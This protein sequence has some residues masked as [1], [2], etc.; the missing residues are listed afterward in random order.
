VCCVHLA[1]AVLPAVLPAS[2][3]YHFPLCRAW[4]NC[5]REP[6]ANNPVPG[7]KSTS[8]KVLARNTRTF[9]VTDLFPGI[10]VLAYGSQ[11]RLCHALQWRK[12]FFN[13]F[14]LK[15]VT[16]D[17]PCWVQIAR[18]SCDDRFNR[19][20]FCNWVQGTQIWDLETKFAEVTIILHHST[21]GGG[22]GSSTIFKKFNEPYAPS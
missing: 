16:Q 21:R 6:H 22:L 14:F 13:F 1:G 15:N 17:S 3:A 19:T 12:H 2:L 9:A 18:K 5:F 11:R 10:G 4:F 20:S 7:K 8:A